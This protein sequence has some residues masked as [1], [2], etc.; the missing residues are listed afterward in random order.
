MPRV[1]KEL[2]ARAVSQL[3]WSAKS[4]DKQGNPIPTWHPVGGATGLYLQCTKN[5]GRSWFYRYSSIE[6][7]GKRIPM[8][9]GT[10]TYAADTEG[11]ITLKQARELAKHFAGLRSQGLDPITE[12]DKERKLAMAEKAA[13]ITFMEVAE[14]WISVQIN[15][16]TW[17]EPNTINRAREYMTEYVYPIIGH[18]PIL[19]V[20][21][22]HAKK[23]LS[24]KTIKGKA[25]L[26]NDSNDTAKRLRGYCENI[27]DK[28]LVTLQKRGVHPNVFVYKNNLDS[29]FAPPAN[30]HEV[31]HR[32][33]LHYKDLPEFIERLMDVQKLAPKGGRPD[34]D[35]FIFGMLACTRSLCTRNADWEDIDL[36][37]RVWTI[38]PDKVGKKTKRVWPVPL[39]ARAIEIIKAQPSAKDMKGRI[40]STLN[41]KQ[42][43]DKALTGLLRL[44]P[45]IKAHKASANDVDTFAVFHGM[46]TTMNGWAK[47]NRYD[48]DTRELMMQHL[49][50][51][52][53]HAAYDRGN[54]LL[55]DRRS[56]IEG[57]EQF[58]F[59]RV[60]SDKVV[61]MKRSAS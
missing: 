27:I 2:S 56:L 15:G 51:S 61:T 9:L 47:E 7:N 48:F 12:R 18:L 19:D 20:R 57:F 14:D 10:Y 35:C 45:D 24:Q 39:H 41:N 58:A 42:L 44:F 33:H 34:I 23:I 50:E 21:Y 43:H 29:D 38:P 4:I 3:G 25:H 32:P 55:E 1:A 52:S 13:A 22:E 46:R 53:T 30:V 31:R 17:K 28:G 26:W 5:G 54:A 37:G 60:T 6:G 59:S 11:A 8:G 49:D 16:G 40:F 36:E